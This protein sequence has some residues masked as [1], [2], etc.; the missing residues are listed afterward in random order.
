MTFDQFASDLPRDRT[1]WF[2]S[3]EENEEAMRKQEVT[4]E[5]KQL[6]RGTFRCAVVSNETERVALF[7]DRFNQALTMYLA[8]PVD[9]VGILIPRTI[10]GDFG[11]SGTNAGNEKLA[12][13]FEGSGA[14]IVGPDLIGSEALAIRTDLFCELTDTLCPAMT[15]PEALAVLGGDPTELAWLRDEVRCFASGEPGTLT[16]AQADNLV[17]R[18]IIWMGRYSKESDKERIRNRLVRNRI[19]RRIR[20]YIEETYRTSLSI[21]DLCKTTGTGARH[22]QRCFKDYFG[23]TI[24]EYLKTVRLDAARRELAVERPEQTT[25]TEI[26]LRHGFT[27][28]GRFSVEFRKRFGESPRETLAN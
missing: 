1:T 7:A 10:H 5:L 11:V 14:D 24:S 25:V 26:A 9:T 22:L 27:H 28:L 3:A 18:V 8:P 20:D 23:I 13:V 17:A 2:D 21:E 16:D 4:Q 6:G 15:T 12:V 19:A